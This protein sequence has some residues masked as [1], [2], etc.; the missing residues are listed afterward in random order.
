MPCLI[1]NKYL[2]IFVHIIVFS[3]C[4]Q[5]NVYSQESNTKT[6]YGYELVDYY[7][8]LGKGKNTIFKAHMNK[9]LEFEV[10]DKYYLTENKW[11][12][13]GEDSTLL[14]VGEFK[15]HFEG[16]ILHRLFQ[17]TKYKYY[18]KMGTWRYYDENNT[19]WK[20]EVYEHGELKYF[21]ECSRE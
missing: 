3:V 17:R 15:R 13:Y 21:L 7:F 14:E 20:I 10:E 8:T 5:W 12:R 1:I 2:F 4:F 19:L 6:R 9:D 11:V 18:I 16:S